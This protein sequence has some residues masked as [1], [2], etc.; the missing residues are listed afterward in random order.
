MVLVIG[1]EPTTY[2]LQDRCSTNWAKPAWCEMRGSNPRPTPCKGAALPT[3]LISHIWW[4]IRGSNPWMH[5][6][7]PCVLTASPIGHGAEYKIWT[8]DQL[9]N[10][11][12]LYHWANSALNLCALL[13]YKKNK[14]F[15]KYLYF[16]IQ[17]VYALQYRCIF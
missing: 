3:E 9:V 4:P 16:F 12:L 5:G 2:G 1:V 7:K 8:C 17:S 11:Q 15:L 6:W 14:K 10:S 13:L